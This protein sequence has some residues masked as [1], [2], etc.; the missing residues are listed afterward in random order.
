MVF[1]LLAAATAATGLLAG[2]SLDQS[3]KQLPARHRIG[4]SAFAEYSRASDLANGIAFYAILGIGAAALNL[5][6]AVAARIEGVS[7][8]QA[9]PVY[10]GAALAL[11]HSLLTALAAPV[12][13]SQRRT[14]D[15]AALSGIFDRFARLQ[16]FR[17]ALQVA[18]FGVNLW[19]LALLAG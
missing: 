15:P 9:G 11:L 18:N 6:A 17:C 2:A 4:P 3:L 12:N 13:F 19:A 10:A 14:N 1:T 8:G 7:G 16:A 5:A